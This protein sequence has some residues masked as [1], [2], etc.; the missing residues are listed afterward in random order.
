MLHADGRGF[1][2]RLAESFNVMF[3]LN[4]VQVSNIY[5]CVQ[6]V[7]RSLKK[8]ARASRRPTSS[9]HTTRANRGAPE[10]TAPDVHH[11]IS[12]QFAESIE[13][14]QIPFKVV[15][16]LPVHLVQRVSTPVSVEPTTCH[17]KAIYHR[18]FDIAVK[19][20]T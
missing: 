18:I 14:V 11:T 12:S 9:A 15:P 2:S 7:S 3:N 6:M 4:S 13:P 16:S 10:L 1:D 20:M 19:F 5:L 8:R 17:L